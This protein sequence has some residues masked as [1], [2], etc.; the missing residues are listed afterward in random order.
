MSTDDPF[1]RW[2]ES[3]GERARAV[4]TAEVD[5]I[6]DAIEARDREIAELR[7]RIVLLEH[8]IAQLGDDGR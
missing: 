1:K 2:S 5:A 7:A 6:R 8:H 4:G 3:W